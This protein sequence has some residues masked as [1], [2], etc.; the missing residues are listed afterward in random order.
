[1]TLTQ[2]RNGNMPAT[3]IERALL[4]IQKTMLVFLRLMPTRGQCLYRVIDKPWE[5]ARWIE[6]RNYWGNTRRRQKKLEAEIDSL[7]HIVWAGDLL[8]P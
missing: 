1:M 4:N 2:E 5:K 3:P 7:E 6:L 8:Y